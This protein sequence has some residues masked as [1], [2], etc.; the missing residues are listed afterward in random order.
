MA[1][2]EMRQTMKVYVKLYATLARSVAGPALAQHPEGMRAGSRI[3][4]ELPES[5]TL[6]DL[7]DYLALPRRD[8]KVFF[9]N[10]RAQDSDYRLQAGDEVGLFPPIG[11]G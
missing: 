4:V 5:S 9:V 3:E 6:A 8:V 1:N 2:C 11:G 7:V 10:G